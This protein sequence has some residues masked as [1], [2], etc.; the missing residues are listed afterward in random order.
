MKK[1]IN[2]EDYFLNKIFEAVESKKTAAILSDRLYDLLNKIDHPI[3]YALLDLNEDTIE[4]DKVTLIDY[5]EDDKSKFTYTIPSKLIDYIEK[6]D[7][8]YKDSLNDYKVLKRVG[9]LVPT[10]WVKHRNSTTIGKV[11][12]KLFP[13]KYKPNGK[14]GEDIESFTNEVKL[15]RTKNDNVFDRFKILKGEDIVTYYNS[16][17]YD[18]RSFSG[19]NLGK[20][21]M[22]S[23]SCGE[24]IEFYAKNEGA[25]L[26]VLMSDEEEDKILGR[27]VLWD[28]EYL[29]DK[30]V[31]RKFL[32]RIYYVYDS[33]LLLFKEFA[34]K[35][36]WLYK[37]DQTMSSD[38]KI[39]DT[40]NNSTAHRQLRTVNTFKE[41]DTYPYMDTMKYYYHED[42]YLTNSDDGD[43]DV[44]FL[45]STGGGFEELDRGIYV[46]FYAERINEDDLIWCELGNEY[47][48]EDD[49]IYIESSGDYATQRY[50]DNNMVYSDIEG[51]YIP[52]E[53]AIWSDYHDTYIVESDSI[54][55]YKEGAS[56][57]DS[58]EDLDQDDLQPRDDGYNN[59]YID[60]KAGVD[61][62]DENDE[63]NFIEVTSLIHTFEIY[64]HKVCDKDKI[65]K[66][67][68]KLYFNDDP[69]KKDE[70]I[71]QKRIW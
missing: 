25:N 20:S 31:D 55:V 57:V 24:F 54:M 44:Y 28:I 8:Y 68:G 3:C 67:K 5:D 45:E 37:I 4:S 16:D 18:S 29:D 1:L 9:K 58:Y 35:N 2:F 59:N 69:L 61:Y 22:R 40:L 60:Y 14:P 17:K 46:E 10:I 34:K 36:G 42:K 33:D 26:V 39:V 19:S 38:E 15:Q 50:V 62:F 48:L 63:D 71:G 6:E 21:C 43:E 23:D 56:D 12:N 7:P 53:D 51:K 27:A 47:R 32:D 41:N 65:F 66:C 30:K 70:L 52:N 11:V 64:V 49:A 13:D